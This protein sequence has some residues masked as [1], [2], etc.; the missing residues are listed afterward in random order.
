MKAREWTEESRQHSCGSLAD[1]GNTQQERLLG[2][3][4]RVIIH[5]IL[6]LSAD[7]V[8]LLMDGNQ[9]GFNGR[10]S[11]RLCHFEAIVFHIL[12]TQKVIQ[13]LYRISRTCRRRCVGSTT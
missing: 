6:D 11:G 12:H 2:F 13:T 9:K 7:D 4:V 8:N 5:M 1:A 3:Q 10:A